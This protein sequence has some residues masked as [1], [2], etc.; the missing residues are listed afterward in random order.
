MRDD[1][2][3]PEINL[4]DPGNSWALD[5]SYY[6]EFGEEDPD[7]IEGLELSGDENH[8]LIVTFQTLGEGPHAHRKLESELLKVGKL[9]QSLLWTEYDDDDLSSWP[10]ASKLS[11]ILLG[12]DGEFERILYHRDT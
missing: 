10:E 2:S 6:G 1:M 4:L 7:Y 11:S 3:P 9:D 5:L 12:E 8:K